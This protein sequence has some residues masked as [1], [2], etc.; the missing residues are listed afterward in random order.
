MVFHSG[1][2]LLF[3][4]LRSLHEVMKCRDM[5]PEK[6]LSR[7]GKNLILSDLDGVFGAGV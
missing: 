7:L 5:A 2:E 1:I 3:N 6:V 4:V